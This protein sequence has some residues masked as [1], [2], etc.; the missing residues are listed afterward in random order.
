MKYPAAS[1]DTE[2]RQEWSERRWSG[3]NGTTM[4]L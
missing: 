1:L 2:A 4:I 3:P